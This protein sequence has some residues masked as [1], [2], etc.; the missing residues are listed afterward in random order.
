M[1][2]EKT[3]ATGGE[4]HR[5]LLQL[6]RLSSRRRPALGAS[7]QTRLQKGA[8]SEEAK[9]EAKERGSARA[10]L[11]TLNRQLWLAVID[12]DGKVLKRS[13]GVSAFP[14]PGGWGFRM[15][16]RWNL[17]AQEE[18]PRCPY[19]AVFGGDS[20]RLA[21]FE[22]QLVQVD[23]WS[24]PLRWVTGSALVGAG[25]ASERWVLG[26]DVPPASGLPN[27]LGVRLTSQG[28]K[29]LRL[30]REALSA[31]SRRMLGDSQANDAGLRE[32]ALLPLGPTHPQEPLP[33]LV[34]ACAACKESGERQ[35]RFFRGQLSREGL[36]VGQPLALRIGAEGFLGAW[37]FRPL[38]LLPV[39]WGLNCNEPSP[40]LSS[41]RG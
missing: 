27:I 36:Q 38:R 18:H 17:L 7:V 28:L 33:V 6:Q 1:E 14:A 35:W 39:S 19:T 34:Q 11:E 21:C 10:W 2:S 24:L 3:P 31:R 41:K 37:L 32:L 12:Q 30:D 23:G 22:W 15:P 13:P 5:D 16:V 29:E 9:R 20:P 8:D 26:S 25:E 40:G 4:T